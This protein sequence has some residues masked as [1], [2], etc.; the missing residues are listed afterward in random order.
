MGGRGSSYK[1]K[2]SENFIDFSE[3]SILAEDFFGVENGDNAK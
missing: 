2:K 1:K 3:G